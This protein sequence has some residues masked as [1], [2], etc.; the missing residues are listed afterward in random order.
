MTVHDDTCPDCGAKLV[1]NAPAGLC[2]QCLL[3]LGLGAD[4]SYTHIRQGQ[5]GLSA[6]QPRPRDSAIMHTLSDVHGPA[7]PSRVLN[8]LDESLGPAPRVLLRDGPA[9]DP[10]P[11]RPGSEEMPEFTGESSRYQLLGEIA[12]GGIGV[13]LKGRDVDLGRDLAIKV[14]LEKHRDHPDMVRRFIEEA[15]IGGQLQHPGIVPVHELG[16]FPDG[17]FYIAMKMVV[18]RT[19]AAQLESRKDPG[20]DRPR[21]VAIFE[22]IC[23]TLAYAHSRGVIHRDLKPSNVMVGNFGEVQV[24]DWGLAKVLDQGGVADEERSLRSQ[25]ES[26]AIRTVRSGSDVGESHAGSVLGTPAYM[27][28]EQ[29][30]G[31]LDVIDERADVFGLGSILC[32]I[33]TGQPAFT[34]KTVSELYRKAERADLDDAFARLASCGAEAELVDLARSCLAAAPKNRLRDA[35]VVLADLTAYITG[36]DERLRAAELAQAKAE[37]K[38]HGERK[39]RVL[40]V[41]LAA[42]TLATALLGGGAW[43][44]VVGDRNRRVAKT[45]EVVSRAYDEALSLGAKARQ[46]VGGDLSEWELAI[47]AAKRAEALL[48]EGESNPEMRGRVENLLTTLGHQRDEAT[49]IVRDRHIVERFATIHNDLGV[50]LDPERANEEYAAAFRDYGVDVEKLDPQEAGSRLASSP[51]ATQIAGALDQWTFL[52]RVKLQEHTEARRLIAIAKLADPDPWRNRLREAL[53]SKSRHQNNEEVLETLDRLAETADTDR[54]PEA[55]VSTLAFALSAFGQNKTAL[56]LLRKTQRVHPDGFW[57]NCQIGREL[58]HSGNFAEAV[59]FFSNAVAVRPRSGFALHNLG[60]VLHGNGQVEEAAAILQR[61][62]E[63]QPD[64]VSARVSL[65]AAWIELGQPIKAKEIFREAK[66]LRPQECVVASQIGQVLMLRGECEMAVSEFQEAIRIKPKNP[67]NHELLGKALLETGRTAEAAASFREAI[68]LDPKLGDAYLSLGKALLVEGKLD[69]ALDKFQ[70]IP[71]RSMSKYAK[72]LPDVQVRE[73]KRFVALDGKL[74]DFLCGKEKPTSAEE[75]AELA[76]L[77]RS[78]KL[79]E[80]S[81]KLWSE[82]FAWEPKLAEDCKSECRYNAACAAALAGCSKGKDA[83]PDD[84]GGCKEWRRKAREWLK[85]EL[86]SYDKWLDGAPQDDQALVPKRLGRWQ[87]VPDLAG[88]R[89]ESALAAL[90]EAEREE[91][92]QLWSQVDEL[93][94]RARNRAHLTLPPSRF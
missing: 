4:L 75:S 5:G 78:K 39:R 72:H 76:R 33:L 73:A 15:Q 40:S 63:M 61:T 71:Y 45:N 3:Q 41:A 27:A 53:D 16:R 81:A 42:S 24:M 62:I 58:I 80:A 83:N 52:R 6:T 46:D 64:N 60:L 22:Q 48:V 19:L 44:W 65:G 34:G 25:D 23:Q 91:C 9:D 30:R 79:D 84:K 47:E 38:A 68:R 37:A 51:V 87:V 70:E 88:I 55:S 31:A 8:N 2:P 13:I 11:V 93:K 54:L 94:K 57:I 85:A 90:P 69:A 17:R 66:E 50:H 74:P 82:A 86:A 59:R 10:R 92:R 28:P 20:E 56:D 77:C 18:G 1:A 36:V 29:A 35:G 12:R 14:L 21:F 67:K 26:L 32:E 89:D 7:A 43:A 49:L